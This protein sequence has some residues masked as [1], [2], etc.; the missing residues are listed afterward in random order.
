MFVGH[1][2]LGMAGKA[3]LP[4]VSLGTWFLAVQLVDL[5]WPV[6]LLLGWEHV[7]VAPG[8]TRMTPLDFYDYPI[9][10]SLV[11]A[12]GWSIA[13]ALVYAAL[14]AAPGASSAMK[15]GASSAPAS[16]VPRVAAT[17]SLLGAAV[18]SHWLLDLLVHRPD[19]PILP[20]GPRVGLG[21]W[22]HPAAEMTLESALF[23]AGAALYLRRT[24]ALDGIGRWATW[25][26]L[27]TLAGVWL[28]AV[29]GPPPPGAAVIGWMGL[30][31]WLFVPWAWWCD[32]H[33]RPRHLPRPAS[34]RG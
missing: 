9:T 26:L 28:A 24:V 7:R 16:G 8:V 2:G 15:S 13:F 11:G 34:G 5:L 18:F 21:L 29:L 12:L 3:A 23:V 6:F 17:A 19:L 20:G 14:K 4:R 25:L 32:R 27:V 33:R 1:F 22:N 30:V 31:T 10:H